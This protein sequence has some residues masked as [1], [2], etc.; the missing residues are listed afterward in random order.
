[1]EKNNLVVG[2]QF[3]ESSAISIAANIPRDVKR[4][5]MVE[6]AQTFEIFLFLPFL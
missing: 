5:K 1:M 6:I 2:H 3:S 4:K